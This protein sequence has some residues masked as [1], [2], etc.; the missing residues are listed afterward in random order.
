ME[1]VEPHA[2]G[3]RFP[4]KMDRTHRDSRGLTAC[5]SL[6]AP[7]MI[8]SARC[9]S[10]STVTFVNFPIQNEFFGACSLS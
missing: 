10:D 1:S 9:I 4:P 2:A 6:L 3:R 8:D 7:L 5:G